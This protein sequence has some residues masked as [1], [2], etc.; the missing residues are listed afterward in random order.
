MFHDTSVPFAERRNITMRI[1]FLDS[2]AFAKQDMMDAFADCGIRYDLF[3]MT[4]IMTDKILILK[5]L[6]LPPWKKTI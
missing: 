5:L 1:L 2:P 4:A 3:F 6:F